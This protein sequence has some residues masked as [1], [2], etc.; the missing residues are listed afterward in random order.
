MKHH[1]EFQ[2]M[3]KLDLELSNK[4]LDQDKIQEQLNNS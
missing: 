2:E 1:Q 3:C 4:L